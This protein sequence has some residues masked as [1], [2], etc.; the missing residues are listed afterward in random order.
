MAFTLAIRVRDV[1]PFVG[2]TER[3]GDRALGLRGGLVT[4]ATDDDGDETYKVS[5][6]EFNTR[7]DH[8]YE[9]AMRACGND[10]ESLRVSDPQGDDATLLRDAPKPKVT[11]LQAVA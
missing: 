5:Y 11:E 8:L 2:T 4:Y 9:P 7:C 1:Q 6:A 10:V 3:D